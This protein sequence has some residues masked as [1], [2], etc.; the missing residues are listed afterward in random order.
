MSLKKYLIL[1]SLATLV[2]WGL[3][4][5][6]IFTINPLETTLL[7]FVLFYFSLALSLAGTFSILGFLFRFKILKKDLVFRQVTEA[8]RQSFLMS[9]LLIIILIL[10]S[11]NLF[12]WINLLILVVG[13]SLLEYFW[14][15]RTKAKI[16]KRK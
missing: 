5:F 11:K 10:L 3:F 2:C 8:F 13:L 12:T 7:G 15:S 4:I 9:L 6:I 1:M 14:V 16:L